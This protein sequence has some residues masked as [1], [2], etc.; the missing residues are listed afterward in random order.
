VSASGT[1]ARASRDPSPPADQR[2]SV[3]RWLVSHPAWPVTALLAGYPLWWLLGLADYMW[4]LLAIPMI[5]RMMAWR[6]HR[7]RR[8]RL[9]PG[10]GLWLLF[11]VWVVAGVST[12]TLT[13]PGTVASPVSHRLISFA[14]R[15]ASYLGVTVL[16]LYVGNL[17]ETE[18][19][20]RKLAWLLGLLGV[21]TTV[22]GVAGML[23]PHIQFSSPFLL[24]V[25]HHLQANSFIQAT[26]HP[27]LSQVQNV[28]GASTQP[29]PKAPFNYT[30]TWGQCLTIT[31]PWLLVAC[32][33]SKSRRMRIFGWVILGLAFVVLVYSLNRGAWIGA[34]LAVAYVAARL[35]ARGRLALLGA[36]TVA[37][38][39]VV[40]A[41]A[42]SPLHTVIS[43]RLQNG[44]SN[45]IRSSLDALAIRDGLSSP[46]L[47]YGDTRQQ[48]GSPK[49]IAVG[50][51]SSCPLCGRNSVG[52]TGQLW[53]LLVCNG[54]VG[55]LF[56]V[57][58]FA[59]GAWRYR[60]DTTPYGITGTLV[61]LLSFVY[62]FTYDAV[63]APLGLT[64]LAYAMLWRNE[65]QQVTHLVADWP[66]E[67][68]DLQGACVTVTR[69]DGHPPPGPAGEIG[70]VARGSVLNITAMVLGAVLSFTLTV[71]VSHW[72]PPRE[73]GALFELIALF[74]ILSY[75]FVLGADTGLTR[76]ISRARAIGGLREVRRIV[77][78]AAVPVLIIGTAAGCAVW[79]AAPALAATFLHGM[80]PA[81]AAADIR[82]V[83]PLVALGAL[84]VCVLAAARGFGRMWPY[85]AVEGLGKPTLRLGLVFAA[86]VAGW[87][88]R[89]ALA[90][91][92]VPIVIGF[93]AGWLILRRLIT[94]EVRA[95]TPPATASTSPAPTATARPRGAGF[96]HRGGRVRG[97]HRVS[98]RAGRQLNRR[99]AADFWRFT[100]PRGFA[101]VFQIVVLWL[102]ILLVGALVSSYAAGIYAAVSKLALLGTFALE[103]T[104]LAIG[105]QLSVL[106]A[107]R[108]RTRAAEVYQST[109]R[110]L[111]LASWPVY[112]MFAIFPAVVLR[113]F[114]PRYV[115]GATALAVI[116]LAMLINLGTGNVTVVLL[117]GGK[118]SW[119]MANTLAALVVN[120]GLNL[121][122]LPRIGIVGAAIAWAASIAVDNVAAVIEVKWLLGLAPFGRGYG[123]AAAATA[124]C[125]GLAGVVM[126]IIDG[127]T[128]PA[129][130]AAAA[131][132][133]IACAAVAYAGRA[134]LQLADLTAA[135]WPGGGR[136]AIGQPS[137]WGA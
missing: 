28:F 25:P 94:A 4:V 81:A 99:L 103:A 68:A 115:A 17:T 65:R 79:L 100:A 86:L 50:P 96:Q 33:A 128:L 119:N 8:I 12:L 84:S 22:L 114:G 101:G 122:L 121:L 54:I 15:T 126:R 76:W 43:Q 134:R 13:A 78:V 3:G 39:A 83:A 55:T 125:F 63:A 77:V 67:I 74:T 72:L 97:L 93:A 53:L 9:P 27:G 90:G 45:D 56:Y 41:I 5:T 49:S 7:S 129:L 120:V 69:G 106:L 29:R 32:Q 88:L 66:E 123:L 107:R 71:L 34:G 42:A 35:A 102:D 136:A 104:R 57:G 87:G 112:V 85:L 48:P 89:G 21:Y 91:W 52:S 40:I 108:E 137:Q 60:R 92:C 116:S 113:I 127:Q 18:L 64:M 10:F 62:L 38:A 16:L 23:A 109:T 75:T 30:N 44:K 124:G 135:L 14:V 20:R 133:L 11:L 110:W 80:D 59:Y 73:V 98:A 111:M 36:V 118:S 58:F 24:L 132:G 31:V 131:A 61:L 95:A 19:P 2:R 117:M 82:I 37:L 26:M 46:I 47:G 51:T 70:A 105:P 6:A 130:V 1:L